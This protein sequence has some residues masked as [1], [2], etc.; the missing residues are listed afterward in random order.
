MAVKQ[1]AAIAVAGVGP[2]GGMS[3]R[4][5]RIEKLKL[6]LWN[7]PA[8]TGSATSFLTPLTRQVTMRRT[9]LVALGV[10]NC[11]VC[12]LKVAC[13]LGARS[14]IRKGHVSCTRFLSG[15][16]SK[17]R[18]KPPKPRFHPNPQV[19]LYS[20]FTEV[21]VVFPFEHV[22]VT[23]FSLNANGST[24]SSSLEF[25]LSLDTISRQDHRCLSETFTLRYQTRLTTSNLI[26]NRLVNNDPLEL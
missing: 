7:S 20:D 11:V 8:I 24:T 19:H 10:D 2:N 12:V 25:G 13:L 23:Y 16:P 14:N 6:R 18:P 15:F 9:D 17:T 21:G 22:G 1:P 26:G 4:V 5:N 3:R